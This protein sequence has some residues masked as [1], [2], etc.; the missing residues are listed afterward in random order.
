[1][2]FSAWFEGSKIVDE[3]GKPLAV[4]HGTNAVFVEFDT[5]PVHTLDRRRM[6][7]CFS[8]NPSFAHT[9]GK[10]QVEAYL[11]I[12]NPLDIRGLSAGEVIDLLPVSDFDQKALR[13]A[14][15]GSDYSQ[16]GLL[17]STNQI[18]LRER[19]EGLGYDGVAYMEGSADAFIVFQ[20]DQIWIKDGPQHAASKFSFCPPVAESLTL[21]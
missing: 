6:G 16:Y 9:Y 21:F 19:L 2:T 17:E 14:F 5:K 12:L 7:T 4:H 15:R 8:V 1:M 20:A 11:R 3:N 13:S 10:H 18:A